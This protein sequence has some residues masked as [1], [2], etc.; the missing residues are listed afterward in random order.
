MFRS[1]AFELKSPLN[2]RLQTLDCESH[3]PGEVAH[4]DHDVNQHIFGGTETEAFV[5][6]AIETVGSVLI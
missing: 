1:E 3:E 2:D 4:P 6:K 5:A